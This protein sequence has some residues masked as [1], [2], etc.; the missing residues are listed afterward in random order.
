MSLSLPVPFIPLPAAVGE[1]FPPQARAL[2][3]NGAVLAFRAIVRDDTRGNRTALTGIQVAIDHPSEGLVW[4]HNP[5]DIIGQEQA[6]PGLVEACF[7]LAQT[8]QNAFSPD[9]MI[10]AWNRYKPCDGEHVYADVLA[11]PSGFAI[12]ESDPIDAMEDQFEELDADLEEGA[13]STEF[14]TGRCVAIAIPLPPQP[15]SH[16]ICALP[17][18]AARVLDEWRRVRPQINTP[19]GDGRVLP[20]TAPDTHAITAALEHR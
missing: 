10:V 13:S 4:I 5:I 8:L 9:H 14:E 6:T 1:A 11:L 16:Q 15:S 20:L 19:W 18:Q 17:K 7:V 12:G 2:L 3:D